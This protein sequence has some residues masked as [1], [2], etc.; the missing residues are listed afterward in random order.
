VLRRIFGPRRD[1]IIGGCR[2]LHNEEL[3]NSDSF[4][5]IIRMMKS[6]RMRWVGHIARMGAK[7]NAY[8]ISM[9]NPEEK[10]ALGR[11]RHRWKDNIKMDLIEIRWG[12]VDWIHVAQDRDQW[13][14]LVNTVMN[15]RVP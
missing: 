15:L 8:T 6:R 3:H 1:V 13:R 12:D 14:A 4:P 9:R 2:K 7:G 5:N 10:R 11:P